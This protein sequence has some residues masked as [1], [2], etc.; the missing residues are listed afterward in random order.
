[1]SLGPGVRRRPRKFTR[2]ALR[3]AAAVAAL[4]LTFGPPGFAGQ[5]PPATRSGDSAGPPMVGAPPST[6]KA[7]AAHRPVV[8]ATSMSPVIHRST[9]WIM[10]PGDPTPSRTKPAAR[11]SVTKPATPPN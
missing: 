9:Y 3:P 8:D 2:A 11:P 1:M 6:V 7:M 10:M 4:A 5:P